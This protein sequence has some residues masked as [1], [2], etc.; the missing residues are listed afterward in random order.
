MTENTFEDFKKH[1]ELIIKIENPNPEEVFRLQRMFARIL[2]QHLDSK[3]SPEVVSEYERLEQSGELNEE[4]K[5]IEKLK[6]ARN[7]ELWIKKQMGC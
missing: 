1:L 4:N 6:Q 7:F 2:S 3:M 5:E